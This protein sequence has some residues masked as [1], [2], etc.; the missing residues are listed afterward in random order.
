MG[1][2]ERE[3]RAARTEPKP[4][5]QS[6]MMP[7][8][9]R[10][11]LWVLCIN[12]ALLA[13]EA[14]IQRLDGGGKLLWLV[15]PRINKDALSQLGPYAYR[16]NGAQ[17]F[18]LLWPAAMGFW[19]MLRR[20]ARRHRAPQSQRRDATSHLLLPA[21]GLMAACPI[22]SASRAAAVVAAVGIFVS[23]ILIVS[24]LRRRHPAIKFGAVL[25]FG[26]VLSTGLY[27]GWEPL[28]A[29]LKDTET[30][31][32]SREEIYDTARGI[33]Q[34]Y[35]LFGTGPGSCESVFQ[36]YRSSMEEYWP[37]PLHNDW[38][39]TLVTFGWA[40][41]ALIA[42]ALGSILARWFL[43]GLTKA[44]W[45]FEAFLWLALAG[46]LAHARFDFP[47]QVYSLLHLFLLECAILLSISR[48]SP[49]A[50]A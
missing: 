4:D 25:F 39:E 20:E 19:W 31:Y 38:L 50:P 17:Y 18:N 7:D 21:V 48:P 28:A 46:C 16:A 45:R 41:S 29:R 47:L 26:A 2:S 32:F 1:K 23:A 12:G 13:G 3:I 35:P 10:Q 30:G 14:I 44:N 34:D 5:D 24:G 37:V 49:T 43:P 9:L 36:L 6:R 22:I 27:L 40:G 11:L 15:Q 8:R 42:L 33:A